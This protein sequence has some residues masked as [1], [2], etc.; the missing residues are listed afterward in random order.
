M[1]KM[2]ES[3]HEVVWMIKQLYMKRDHGFSEKNFNKD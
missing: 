3:V 1:K 2:N